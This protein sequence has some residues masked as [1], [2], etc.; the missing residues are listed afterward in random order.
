MLIQNA[1]AKI[2]LSLEV[3]GKREDGYH[4]IVSVMQLIDLHDTLL[5]S[6]ADELTIESDSP[7]LN[8]EGENNL[9]WK[10][11]RLL[12]GATGTSNGAQIELQK[13]IPISAGLGGGSSDAAA[14]LVGLSKLWGVNISQEEMSRLAAR[15]GS[16]VPFFLGA[17]TALVQGRGERVTPLPLLRPCW[18]LLIYQPCDVERKTKRLYSSLFK[19]EM[20]AGELTSEL[21]LAIKQGDFPEARLLH[22]SFER[23]AYSTFAPLNETRR[24][25]EQLGAGGIHVS[26]SGPTIF[27]LFPQEQEVKAQILREILQTEGFSVLLTRT[28]TRALS[29]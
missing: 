3:L 27:V 23:A 21:V 25:L 16:D 1:Y 19:E 2:N 13:R 20:T 29:A 17:P 15:L 7:K 11:A 26:G 12:A 14:A 28:R 9:I 10:A 18:V 22:N 6:P 4:D 5:F 8:A 24:Q